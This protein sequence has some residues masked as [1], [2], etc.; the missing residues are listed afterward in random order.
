MNELEIRKKLCLGIIDY[1]YK[2][3]Q[4]DPRFPDALAEYQRQL[5]SIQA[6]IDAGKPPTIIVGLKTAKLFGEVK[7]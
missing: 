1:L 6:K 2:N 5:A 4:D 3:C 7:K